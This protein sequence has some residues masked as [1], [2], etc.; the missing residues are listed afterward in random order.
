MILM[1]FVNGTFISLSNP[2]LDVLL[3]WFISGDCISLDLRIHASIVDKPAWRV[4]METDLGLVS[5]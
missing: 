2:E 5:S 1:W 3:V 4:D